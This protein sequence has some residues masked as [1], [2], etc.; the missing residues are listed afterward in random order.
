MKKW[1]DVSFAF[2]NKFNELRKGKLKLN[3]TLH[4]CYT[5]GSIFSSLLFFT[6]VMYAW[7]MSHR[8]NYD[9]SW[10]LELSIVDTSVTKDSHFCD[11]YNY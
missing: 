4:T 1:I 7:T 11:V 10:T 9:F 6:T 3:V 5:K 8:R 2:Q